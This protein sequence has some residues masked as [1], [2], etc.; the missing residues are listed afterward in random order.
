MSTKKNNLLISSEEAKHICD[1][2]QYGEA[3]F[4]ERL[5]LNLRVLWCK[6][7]KSYSKRN[8]NLTKLCQE[9]EI[10]T[11]DA[12]KKNEMKEKINTSQSQV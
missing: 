10:K 1:K 9:A 8:V 12:Q 2:V 6:A 7:T 3:T 11:L 4:L 5:K